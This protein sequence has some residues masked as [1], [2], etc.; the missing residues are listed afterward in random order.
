M[1]ASPTLFGVLLA[2]VM[3][4]ERIAAATRAA[5]AVGLTGSALVGLAET[6]HGAS[7]GGDLLVLAASVAAVTTGVGVPRMSA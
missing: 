3:L 6:G 1:I 5:V 4:G 7:L 2:R